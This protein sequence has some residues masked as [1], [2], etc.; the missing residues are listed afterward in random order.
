MNETRDYGIEYFLKRYDTPMELILFSV[1]KKCEV[2]RCS[3]AVL[4][5]IAAT[6]IEISPRYFHNIYL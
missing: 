6:S 4:S 1:F 3:F 2:E 5:A